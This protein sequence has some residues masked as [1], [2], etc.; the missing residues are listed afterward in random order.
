MHSA[1]CRLQTAFRLLGESSGVK[2]TFEPSYDVVAARRSHA[3]ACLIRFYF[4][5]ININYET[6]KKIE[7]RLA[8]RKDR[9][10][11]KQA[12]REKEEEEEGIFDEAIS[13][14]LKLLQQD[15]F[16]R[17]HRSIATS[18]AAETHNP[19]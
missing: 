17:F 10:E 1:A 12:E 2:H 14:I 16:A 13:C 18:D 7:L 8:R 6:K 19:K 15:S 3:R 5:Q 4:A 11:E 9:R